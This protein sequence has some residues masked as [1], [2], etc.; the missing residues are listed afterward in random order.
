MSHMRIRKLIDNRIEYAGRS[1]YY[2]FDALPS[3]F[4]EDRVVS[5]S[6]SLLQQFAP[7]AKQ[8]DNDLN[9]EWIVR[10]FFAAKMILGASVMAQSLEFAESTNLRSVVSYL[11]YYT[12][13][14]SLRAILFTNPNVAWD[15]GKLLQT[16]HSK[17]INVATNV[18]ASF[19]SDTA[20]RVKNGVTHLKAFRELI[21]YRAPSSGDCFPKPD[22]DVIS[23]CQLF[24]EVA[25][26][27]SELI[28]A[29]VEKHVCGTFTLSPE[30]TECISNVEIDG[31]QFFDKE[32]YYRIGYLGR[33]HP[34]PTNVLHIMSEGHVE[35]FFGS[36]CSENQKEGQFDP[37][38]NCRI[39]FDVP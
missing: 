11:Q 19:D 6:Q 7:T 33:K 18:I 1:W 10:P 21:S 8:W 2:H 28:E 14:H 39:L 13:L 17:S 22:F 30:F 24:L 16:T 5:F 32:D 4:S 20:Q 27:Q 3:N 23:Y 9:S 36:W 15:G 38:D 12:V 25:Q 37:D 29:S 35:D 26:L 34:I 31:R